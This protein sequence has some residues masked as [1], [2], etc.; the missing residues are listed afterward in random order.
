MKSTLRFPT[1]SAFVFGASL[2]AV[3]SVSP[4]AAKGRGRPNFVVVLADNLRW[5]AL[6]ASGHPFIRNPSIDRL[7]KEGARFRNA[8]VT[9]PLCSPS[10]A[11][12]LT[13]RYARAHQIRT[14]DDPSEVS[15]RFATFPARLE[16]AGYDTAFIGKWHM[17]E[18]DTPR[19]GF[20]HW[21]GLTGQGS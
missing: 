5:D 14:N 1:C 9:T 10:R 8:F 18:D 13:G 7:S 21:V 2:A 4:A 6:E 11:S 20:T 12:F 3:L 16:N 19:R 17:G 15:H